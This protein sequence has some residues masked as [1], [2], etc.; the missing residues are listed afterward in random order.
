MD[1]ETYDYTCFSEL[2]YEFDHS[3]GKET[4]LKIKQLLSEEKLGPYV[5]ERIDYIRQ[6]KNDLQKEFYKDTKSRF[7]LN[8][9]SGYASVDDFDLSAMGK[10]FSKKYHKVEKP[11][12]TRM[13]N[14]SVYQF[15]MRVV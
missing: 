4:E 8:C 7:Y 14:T 6:L 1:T 9:L 12:L 15:Y 2:V 3:D 11:D 10:F 13:V 5:Q